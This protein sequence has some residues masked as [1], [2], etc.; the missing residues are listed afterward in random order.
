M[1][2]LAAGGSSTLVLFWNPDCG[3]CQQLLP[4]LRLWE[5]DL[6][7]DAHGLLVVSTGTVEANQA[8]RLR[9]PVVLDADLEVGWSFGV[10]GTPSAVLV[11]ADGHF[12]SELAVGGLAVR[13]LAGMDQG[14][15]LSGSLAEIR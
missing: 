4:D 14:A 10:D 13:A 12:E 6:P 7:R 8:L 5:A 15:A 11:G 2:D 1:V 3:F 9:A